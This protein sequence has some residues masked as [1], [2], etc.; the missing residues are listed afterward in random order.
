MHAVSIVGPSAASA[1]NG[2]PGCLLLVRHDWI[3]CVT[4][5]YNLSVPTQKLIFVGDTLT[6]VLFRYLCNKMFS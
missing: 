1:L 3:N 2:K 5:T 6:V 4:S